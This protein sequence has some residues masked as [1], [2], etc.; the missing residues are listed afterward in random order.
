[1]RQLQPESSSAAALTALTGANAHTH[2]QPHAHMHTHTHTQHNMLRVYAHLVALLRS[3]ISDFV[4]LLSTL[5]DARTSLDAVCR[6]CDESGVGGDVVPGASCSSS[7]E[8]AGE[9]VGQGVLDGARGRGVDLQGSWQDFVAFVAE[10]SVDVLVGSGVCGVSR[11]AVAAG[12]TRLLNA[13][14]FY[15]VLAWQQVQAALFP[16]PPQLLLYLQRGGG[17]GG[18]GEGGGGGRGGAEQHLHPSTLAPLQVSAAQKNKTGGGE[19]GRG[20]TGAGAGY[21]ALADHTQTHTYTSHADDGMRMR[22]MHAHTHMHLAS[23][24]KRSRMPHAEMRRGAAAAAAEE[25]C[26]DAAAEDADINAALAMA[27]YL[28]GGGGGG[29]ADTLGLMR[30]VFCGVLACPSSS[31]ALRKLMLSFRLFFLAPAVVAEFGSAV[32]ACRQRPLA[33]LAALTRVVSVWAED[34]EWSRIFPLPHLDSTDTRS[35]ASISA[36]TAASSTSS[37]YTRRSAAVDLLGA[38]STPRQTH[39]SAEIANSSTSTAYTSSGASS[40]HRGSSS[41]EGG[42]GGGGQGGDTTANRWSVG[43]AGERDGG[44]GREEEA[45]VWVCLG[46]LLEE[47]GSMVRLSAP[48]RSPA[49]LPL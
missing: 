3:S 27:R 2:T 39:T 36:E 15:R 42:G 35:P 18:G 9:G 8:G 6:R 38:R 41:F 28:G 29:A 40:L 22:D 20:L 45:Q 4:A 11:E 30:E 44:G 37:I 14:V 31:H 48:T 7:G 33:T 21:V 49:A 46:V 12:H 19:W 43:D 13:L 47:R 17:G 34:V 1:M 32:R 24:P 5:S 26:A 25:A 23:T 10:V 16:I